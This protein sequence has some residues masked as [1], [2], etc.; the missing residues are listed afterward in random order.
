MSDT[1]YHIGSQEAIIIKRRSMTSKTGIVS[2][3]LMKIEN[4]KKI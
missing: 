2:M 1:N 3:L 4:E